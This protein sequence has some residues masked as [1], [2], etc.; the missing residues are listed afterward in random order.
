MNVGYSTKEAATP[1]Q[2]DWALGGCEECKKQHSSTSDAVCGES[3]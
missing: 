3:K 1:M 2:A